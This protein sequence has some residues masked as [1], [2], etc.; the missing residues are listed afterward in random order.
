MINILVTL[1]II[2]VLLY[3]ANTILPMEGNIKKIANVI[4]I[5]GVC[6]WL[7]GV[8]GIYQGPWTHSLR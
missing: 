3:L 5:L 1:V 2:G 8:F 6:I 7:L 4:V